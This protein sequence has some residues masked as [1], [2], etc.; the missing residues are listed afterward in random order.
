MSDRFEREDRYI[1]IKRKHL[2]EEVERQ[3]MAWLNVAEVRQVPKAVV[4]EGDWPEYEPVWQMIEKRVK[5]ERVALAPPNSLVDRCISILRGNLQ[6]GLH[7]DAR[8]QRDAD[9]SI[10]EAMKGGSTWSATAASTFSGAEGAGDN[11]SAPSQDQLL[12][13]AL[14]E[15]VY[16]ATHLSPEREDRSHWCKI[17]PEC[18]ANARYVLAHYTPAQRIEAR[19]DETLQAARPEGQEPDGEADA[20]DTGCDTAGRE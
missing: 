18:L 6:A 12:F 14:A 11:A 1:V 8:K 2:H 3:L 7:P 15:F 17:S 5:N 16:E 4:V 10:L 13:D 9:I 20:P 19:S